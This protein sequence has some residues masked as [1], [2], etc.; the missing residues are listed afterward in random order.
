SKDDHIDALERDISNEKRKL[1]KEV[2]CGRRKN[3]LLKRVY[4]VLTSPYILHMLTDNSSTDHK[5]NANLQSGVKQI[6]KE[7]KKLSDDSSPNNSCISTE[8]IDIDSEMNSSQWESLNDEKFAIDFACQ[9]NIPLITETDNKE[10]LKNSQDSWNRCVSVHEKQI[11]A[12]DTLIH[13]L[14]QQNIENA[15]NNAMQIKTLQFENEDILRRANNAESFID[16]CRL[17]FVELFNDKIP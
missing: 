12:R 8:V 6:A 9:V 15:K 13:N 10:N 16:E 4:N 2:E 11:A 3:A 7:I 14:Q 5:L 1:N 17:I